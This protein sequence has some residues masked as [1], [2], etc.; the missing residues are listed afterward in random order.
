M[1]TDAQTAQAGR[2]A[3]TDENMLAPNAQQK[4]VNLATYDECPQCFGTGEKFDDTCDE[5]RGTGVFYEVWVSTESEEE[6]PIGQ[7]GNR[8]KA[9]REALG[10]CRKRGWKHITLDGRDFTVRNARPLSEVKLEAELMDR[11]SELETKLAASPMQAV[12]AGVTSGNV[13]K[14]YR[15]WSAS[16]GYKNPF[17]AVKPALVEFKDQLITHMLALAVEA[18]WAHGCK[19]GVLYIDTPKGQISWHL[20]SGGKSYTD[21]AYEG[22]W[23]GVRNSDQIICELLKEREERQA[24]SGIQASSPEAGVKQG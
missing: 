2:C 12:V 19:S 6:E 15:I 10:V 17:G 18:G 23:S 4:R 8:R 20:L 21:R 14:F 7:S 16:A 9:V 1:A 22:G 3:L 13:E 11:I 24:F 5:C